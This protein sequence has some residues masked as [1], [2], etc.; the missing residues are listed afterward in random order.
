MENREE[1]ILSEIRTMMST[2]RL[3]IDSLDAKIANL[4]ELLVMT[5]CT[6]VR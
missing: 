6:K 4:Q 2:I 1:R 5:T 3:Q